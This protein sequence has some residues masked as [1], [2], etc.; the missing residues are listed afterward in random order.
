[1]H[2]YFPGGL[3]ESQA[4][5]L[6]EAAAGSYNFELASDSYKL[7]PRGA[8]DLKG[9]ATNAADVRGLLQLVKRDATQTTLVQ[10]GG[11][12]YTWNG[13]ST[14]SSAGVC[15]GSSQLRDVTWSLSDYLVITDLQKLTVVKKWDGT[16]F[17]TLSTGLGTDL[18]AKYGVV[19][20]GRMW[21]FNVTTS[22]D[23]PHLMVASAFENPQSYDTTQRAESGV[24]GTGLEAF[25][26]LSP[27]LR[28]ING[29]A[30]TVAGDLII[31]SLEGSLFIL[32]GTNA[33][34]YRWDNFYPGSQAVGTESLAA[35]GNDVFYMRK[36][37]N[38]ESVAATQKYGDVEADD[39][40]RWI[41]DTVANLTASITVYDQKNQKVFFFVAG[42][43]LVFFKDIFYGGALAG[44]SGE[45]KKLSP[46]SVYR[47][48]HASGFS[49]NAAKFM[50]IPG[51]TDTSVYFGGSAGQ[52]FDMNGVGDDGDGGTSD[53]QVIRKTRF[54]D[55]K[56]G[57]NFMRHVTRGKVHYQRLNAIG[58]NIELDWGDEYNTS[59]ASITLKGQPASGTGAFYMGTVYYGG[60]YYYNEGFS[61]AEKRSHQTFSMVGRGSGC[62][63]TCSTL[64]SV[65]FEVHNVELQ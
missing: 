32:K 36:G 9:T 7:F 42:K 19:H 11:V 16:T 48:S 65:E 6:A 12:V 34:D 61:F 38:I 59:T 24:F 39:L 33:S 53:I 43:V 10:A 50:N 26:M 18:Y 56:D 22:S 41:S 35:T 20:H 60:A 45:K 58:F 44:P 25:Y 23:T 27:D 46:W 14:F 55:E 3:N 30:K 62:V 40:S 13:A 52:I 63:M 64:D 17:S 21:L 15:N 5:D 1:M 29:V 54:I 8:F 28:P 37:G 49:T 57:L 51:S 2:V 31:S 4:P 47:T